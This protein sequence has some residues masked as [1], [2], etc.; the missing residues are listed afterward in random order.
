MATTRTAEVEQAGV[1]RAAEAAPAPVP[2]PPLWGGDPAI[3]GLPIFAAGS[4]ALG[5]VEVGYVP[6]AAAG[7]ALPIIFAATGLGLLVST[8]WAAS[9][10]QT[11]VACIF[12]LFTGF[13]L[14]YAALV[15]GLGHGWFGI[16]V[17]GVQ[18][19]VAAFLI[20]WSIVMFAL[21]IATVR[22]PVAFTT[23]VALVVTAL[24][25]LTIVDLNPPNTTLRDI[26]GGVIFAF[27]ALGLYLFLGAASVASGGRAFPLGPPLVKTVD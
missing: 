25:M 13:W 8:V 17:L 10:G 26:A 22:L 5:F 1:P 9:L 14:S 3:L 12:G 20:T 23:V 4:I 27:A 24:V 11:M 15:L 16:P 21:T 2:T 19:S 7:A 18:K 6:P